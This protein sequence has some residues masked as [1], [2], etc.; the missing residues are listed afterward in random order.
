MS[1]EVASNILAIAVSFGV[2]LPI[3]RQA[4]EVR[5]RPMLWLGASVACDGLEW[6]FW[7]LCAFTP[8]YG[9]SL[10]DAFAILCRIFTSVAVIC[11]LM[12]TRMMFRPS[13]LA[14]RAAIWLLSGAM[15]LGFVGGGLAGDWG[16][17]RNDQIWNWIELFAQIAGYGWT[18]W[19]ALIYHLRLRRHTSNGL[20]DPLV[21]HRLLWWSVYAGLYLVAQIGYGVVLAFYARLTALDMLLACLTV[22]GEF[23]LWL[24]F[25]PPDRLARWLRGEESAAA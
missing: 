3:L 20:S 25:F 16:G 9:T 2:S 17:W 4:Y 11:L 1:A 14:A 5:D 6:L 19:E 24:A 21:T 15:L 8:A 7:T 18:A 22:A 12:F 23:A 10:G 13:E